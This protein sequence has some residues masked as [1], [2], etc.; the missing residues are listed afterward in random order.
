MRLVDRTPWPRRAVA[1]PTQ[2]TTD[3]SQSMTGPP[4]REV[5]PHPG[6]AGM[7]DETRVEKDSSRPRRTSA[8]L[9]AGLCQDS[10]ESVRPQRDHAFN[11]GSG[12]TVQNDLVATR[13]RY[14]DAFV[15][16]GVTEPGGHR[17]HLG[18][19]NTSGI[20]LHVDKLLLAMNY[21]ALNV[22]ILNETIQRFCPLRPGFS[23][24]DEHAS[25]QRNLEGG[26]I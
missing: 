15:P 3:G 18:R 20:R 24:Q 14:N 7:V 1:Q 10:E 5:D 6:R 13:Q 22:M 26:E 23:R 25:G 17:L 16:Q 2:I 9:R 12:V 19:G 8:R 21:P 4:T 11:D